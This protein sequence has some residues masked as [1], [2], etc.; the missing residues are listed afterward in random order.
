MSCRPKRCSALSRP[1]WGWD[2]CTASSVSSPRS[3]RGPPIP[4]VACNL[5]TGPAGGGCQD[6]E[7]QDQTYAPEF[8]FNIGAQYIFDLGDGY[9]L[10]PRLNYGHVGPQW[11]TL[12]ENP[13]R[14]DRIEDRNIF[15]AQLAFTTGEWTA[16]LYGTNITDQHYVG[17]INTGMR[18]AG[19]PRQFGI[20]VL[21]V[22]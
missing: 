15:N 13:A 19:P 18:F 12:F 3:T 22:F 1:T 10:T 16:T 4:F 14:G 8:T 17:A 7:G 5:A 6:L 11:A 2:G 20:R 9:A 21:K